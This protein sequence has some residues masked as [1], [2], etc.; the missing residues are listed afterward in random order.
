MNKSIKIPQIKSPRILSILI[1]MLLSLAYPYSEISAAANSFV[2]QDK[3]TV[4]GTVKDVKGE[5]LIGVNILEK[6]TTTGTITDVNGEFTLSVSSENATLEFSYIGFVTQEMP[7]GNQRDF[8][9]TLKENTTGLDEVVVVGYGSQ[10]KATVTGSISQVSGEDIKKIST[11]N[12]TNTLAGKTAGVIANVR[13][14]EPGEDNATIFIRGKGT[15]GNTDPL[16]IVDGIADRS[17]SRLNPDDIES[18]SVL[19]DASAAIYGARAA[20]GVILVTTKKGKAGKVSVNYN[21]DYTISQPTRIPEMLNSYQYA[22]YINEYDRGHGISTPTYSDEILQK[23]KDGS[24]PVNYPSTDWWSE[25][26]KTWAAK[27]QH[28]VSFSGGSDKVQFYTSAQYMWQDAIYKNSPQ[29]YSQYQFVTNLDAQLSKRIKFS[30][31]ILGRQERRKR[32]IYSTDYLFGYFLTT[33]P[34]A[35]AY[36]PNGLPSVGY[37]NVISNAAI[38]V[39]DK[40][41]TSE[42][43]YNIINLK[44]SLHVDLDFITEG[45]YAEGYSALDYSFNNGRDISHPYDLYQY[46]MATGEYNSMRSATGAISLNSWAD[47]SDRTT[48]NARLGYKRTFGAHKIDAFAAYEQF[49][50]NYNNVSASRTNYLS[51]AIMEIFAGSDD[52]EDWGTGGYAAVSSRQNYFGRINYSY[53]DKYLAEF[54]LRYDGSMNF[55]KDKRWGLFPAFSGGWVISEESFFGSIK[56]IVNF[57]KLKGSWGMM[58]NDNVNPFQFLSSYGFISRNDHP[59]S[60][61]LFGESLQKGLLEKVTANPDI[62]WETAKTTN[63]GV[64]AQFLD[65]KFNLDFDYFVSHRSDIL[66][67]R[68]ASIPSYA[69][70]LLPA[71]NI[72]KVKNSGIEVIAGYKGSRGDFNWNVTGNFTYAENEMVYI[73]EAASTPEWQRA[74]GHPI[75]AMVLYDALGIYQT[76]EQIDNSVHIQGAKPGDLIYR[77]TND[78]GNITYADAIRVNESATPKIVYGLTLNGSYK[79]IDLNVFFQGQAKAKILVQP[80][81]NMMTDFYTD[82]WSDSKTDEQNASAK[83][84]RA[85]IKETYGDDFNGRASTWWMRDASFLRLKSVELGYTLPE[86]V[87]D[88]IGIEKARIFVNGTNLFTIDKIKVFDPEISV[89]SVNAQA[90][91]LTAYPLQ[92]M[93]TAGVNLTF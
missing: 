29:D 52:P 75:D 41:G 58:G 19:K 73:D 67:T 57:L 14:G 24:D 15:T 10:K 93:I 6:G 47:N 9:V 45:L 70:L 86:T 50:Y 83:W 65:G 11:A 39:T 79:G 77:D 28:S 74:T 8:Q 26:A 33:K 5:L 84:P 2:Q 68:N 72:G 69:G 31:N 87:M 1:C 21:G 54:S 82:R 12:L 7:V 85:F 37:E 40:P 60:G 88:K 62:T 20:N 92:R 81:M 46:D 17:F 90:N 27:T 64:S 91:G 89:N 4:K 56:P 51:T 55:P 30:M 36:F 38:M 35:T 23:Y 18:I 25:V 13:S 49:K 76:Q 34:L 42:K 44:P 61:V 43:K 48:V 66:R 71:E 78:D 63:I 80:T 3:V 32:G 53:N 59:A 22:T 16:I